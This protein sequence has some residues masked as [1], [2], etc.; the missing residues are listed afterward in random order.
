MQ[1]SRTRRAGIAVWQIVVL[2]V[3][4]NL[5]A[6]GAVGYVVWRGRVALREKRE[7][8]ERAQRLAEQAAA[9]RKREAISDVAPA[10]LPTGS[11]LEG[12]DELDADG[13]PKKFVSQVGLRSLLHFE[14]YA[15]LTAAMER[16]QTDFEADP[17]KEYWP[18]DAVDAFGSA[19]PQLRPKLDAWAKA[20]PDSFA[21][22]LARAAHLVRVGLFERGSAWTKDTP[23]SNFVAMRTAFGEAQKDIERAMLH[24]PKLVT[25][26]RLQIQMRAATS[27]SDGRTEVENATTV[28]PSCFLVR[29]AYLTYATPRWGGSYEEMDR[30]AAAAPV[31]LNPRLRFLRGYADL[32]RAK[33]ASYEKK[34]A[35]A[36]AFVERACSL[37]EYW[38]FLLER[39]R[40]RHYANDDLH[41][42]ED[43]KRAEELRPRLPEILFRRATIFDALND[44]EP[45]GRDL[46]DGLRVDPADEIG[47][48]HVDRVAKGLNYKGDQFAKA[49]KRND[50]IRMLDLAV[51]LDPTNKEYR[52]RRASV[53]AGMIGPREPGD[54]LASL[55]AK[56]KAA[57]DDFRA[58]QALDYA[59]ARKGDYGRVLEIWNAYLARHP[60]DGRA[61]MERGGAYHHLGRRAEARADAVKACDLGVNEGCMR[62][63]RTP[64]P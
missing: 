34:D 35:E 4:F 15:E 12:P 10:P 57:P 11:L 40:Y 60:D 36:I 14:K 21:P 53:I 38:F 7:D 19:E 8:A 61:Y 64:A 6:A 33:V 43:A 47:R 23:E 54:D 18:H 16:F 44:F 9:A 31:A 51:E 13:Y 25:A 39:A 63:K 45:A 37:G 28:C 46:L 52:H 49:G 32:D 27:R 55:E 5:I 42:L 2:C 29:V 20:T 62:V 50:A 17:R 22:Y 58:Q 59:L 3:L 1:E 56:A 48:E 41:A 30:Y 24:H 26:L